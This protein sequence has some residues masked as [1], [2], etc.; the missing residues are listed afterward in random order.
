M[1]ETTTDP[2]KTDMKGS[3][4][5]CRREEGN[6]NVLIHVQNKTQDSLK[7]QKEVPSLTVISV[8]TKRSQDPH[9][10]EDN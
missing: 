5:F 2:E 8:P 6:V 4:L 7:I 3:I 9:E 10:E 1:F